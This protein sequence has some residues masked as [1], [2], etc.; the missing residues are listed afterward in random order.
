[1]SRTLDMGHWG[2]G[3]SEARPPVV[4]SEPCGYR[5]KSLFISVGRSTPPCV[6]TRDESF[7]LLLFGLFAVVINDIIIIIADW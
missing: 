7:Y 3:S 5:P 1:M 6:G 2:V 4:E